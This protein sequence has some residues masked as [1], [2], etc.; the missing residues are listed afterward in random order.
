ML[1]TI[2]S[3]ATSAQETAISLLE[4]DIPFHLCDG[5][6]PITEDYVLTHEEIDRAFQANPS[7]NVGIILGEHSG[8][9]EFATMRIDNNQSERAFQKLMDGVLVDTP[10]S[11]SRY[12]I[13]RFFEL[14]DRLLSIGYPLVMYKTVSIVLGEDDKW[15][16][17]VPPSISEGAPVEWIRSLDDCDGLFQRLPDAVIQRIL[18]AND[19]DDEV[20]QLPP[21][22]AMR[23]S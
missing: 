5:K 11:A 9:M 6:Q 16:S 12:G 8:V 1:T 20:I 15:L 2:N 3:G 4:L 23:M 21:N 22:L 14:D 19:N 7:L 13:H 17:M 10:T 18:A